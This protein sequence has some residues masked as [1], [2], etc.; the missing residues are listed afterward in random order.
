MLIEVLACDVCQQ[1]TG[2]ETWRITPP[3]GKT[4]SVDLCKRH[5]VQLV[6]LTDSALDATRP[7]QS[8]TKPRKP[9]R[10]RGSIVQVI[11]QPAYNGS[12]SD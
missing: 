1:A 5:A 10:Q 12:S 8:S 2:V 4:V 9:R 6:K 7:Q 3:V 11:D